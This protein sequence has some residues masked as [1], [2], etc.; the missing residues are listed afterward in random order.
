[1]KNKYVPLL[2]AFVRINIKA[3]FIVR[4]VS[5]ARYFPDTN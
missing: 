1:M 4:T 5:L 3:V 2:F